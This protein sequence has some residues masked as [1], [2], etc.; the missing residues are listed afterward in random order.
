MARGLTVRSP[1]HA[2]VMGLQLKSL[3]PP[4]P[5]RPQIPKVKGGGTKAPPAQ[6]LESQ[7]LVVT[8]TMT[9]REAKKLSPAAPTE[10]MPLPSAHSA[11]QPEEEPASVPKLPKKAA[12]SPEQIEAW[13][14]RPLEE[15]RQSLREATMA[16]VDDTMA[17]LADLRE[18]ASAGETASIAEQGRGPLF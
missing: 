10:V 9:T 5:Q 2:E 12:P 8:L 18:R 11:G 15:Q 13:T 4:R 7:G 16:A 3:P 6:L 1:P 14:Q 17:R